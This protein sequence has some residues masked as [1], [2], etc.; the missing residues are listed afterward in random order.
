MESTTKNEIG[1]ND[2]LQQT[3][4]PNLKNFQSNNFPFG[5]DIN[6]F[7][8]VEGFLFHNINGI[9]DESNWTQINLTMA[10]LNITC[11]GLVEINTT[12]RGLTFSKWNDITRKTF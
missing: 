10:E 8:E 11:F 2:S 6:S 7:S 5:D 4:I 9:K 12:L 3:K 1:R